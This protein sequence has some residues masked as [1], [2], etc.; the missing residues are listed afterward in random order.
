LRYNWSQPSNTGGSN[1]PY[2]FNVELNSTFFPIPPGLLANP[3][4]T[5][6]SFGN[7]FGDLFGNRPHT[8]ILFHRAAV[9]GALAY[10][11]TDPSLP[12]LSTLGLSLHGSPCDLACCQSLIREL[13]LPLARQHGGYADEVLR[14]QSVATPCPRRSGRSW[15][16]YCISSNDTIGVQT[17]F[18]G[19]SP[20]WWCS[21]STAAGPHS[22]ERT[23]HDCA[24]SRV[25]AWLELDV[26][27]LW[28]PRW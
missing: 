7:Y 21:I 27:C 28:V 24:L 19:R 10:C 12:S 18:G 25:T 14:A 22:K 6:T 8:C 20:W 16:S 15:I 17:R 1:D 11:P 9:A 2:R 13:P 26:S 23:K 3:Q 4:S 5:I